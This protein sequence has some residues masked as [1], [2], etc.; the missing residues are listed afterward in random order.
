MHIWIIKEKWKKKKRMFGSIDMEWMHFVGEN[1]NFGV[2]KEEN[3][4]EL[5]PSKNL[6][7]KP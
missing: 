6:M 5:D 3:H 1:M 4:N 7:L 2:W